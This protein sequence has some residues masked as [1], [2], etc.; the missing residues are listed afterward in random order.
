MNKR[1]RPRRLSL[2]PDRASPIRAVPDALVQLLDKLIQNANDFAPAE[3][4]ALD[5]MH[6]QAGTK[7]ALKTTA[8]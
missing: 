3:A 2:V 5:S 7:Y 4:R 6:I 8:R 1:M